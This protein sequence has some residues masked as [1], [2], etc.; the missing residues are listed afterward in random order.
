MKFE[1][2][3]AKRQTNLRKHGLDFADVWKVFR[4]PML[5]RLDRREDYGED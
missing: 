5:A 2:D 3:E 4:G 1:W